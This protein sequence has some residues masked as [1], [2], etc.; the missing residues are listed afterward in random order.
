[1]LVLLSHT[2]KKYG[3]NF[4]Q[5]RSAVYFHNVSPLLSL[6][7]VKNG[8]RGQGQCQLPLGQLHVQPWRLSLSLTKTLLSQ[9]SYVAA[10]PII[11]VLQKGLLPSTI[12]HVP[13]RD[14]L[15]IK[16]VD[17]SFHLGLRL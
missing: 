8:E 1:M 6:F 14:H 9:K 7:H 2:V 4:H 11:I 13:E 10:N 15:V 5:L 17:L 16:T 12:L 3:Q